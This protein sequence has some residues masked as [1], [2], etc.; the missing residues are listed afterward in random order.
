M[1][2]R[3][4]AAGLCLV[5]LSAGAAQ[6]E[7]YLG[8]VQGESRKIPILVL[9]LS[10]ETGNGKLSSLAIEVLQSDL[11]RSQIFDVVD[12]KKLDV[13]HSGPTEPTEAVLKRAGT[14][15]VSGVVW[16]SLRKKGSELLLSGRLYDAGSAMKMTG[17][18][19]FGNEDTFRRMIHSLCR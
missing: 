13:S 12:P 7:Y 5:F 1:M 14:F 11:R 6:S 17:R 15:G 10:N 4:I 18:E 8:V 16:A 2:K 19:Y 3:I 9:D